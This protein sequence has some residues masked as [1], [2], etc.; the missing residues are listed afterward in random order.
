MNISAKVEA[1]THEDAAAV[2]S[3][4]PAEALVKIQ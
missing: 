3:G 4:T 1:F 2:L